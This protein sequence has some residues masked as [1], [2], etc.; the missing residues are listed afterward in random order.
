[1]ITARTGCR[2]PDSGGIAHGGG[3]VEPADRV[4]GLA[5]AVPHYGPGGAP[6]RPQPEGRGH[7]RRMSTAADRLLADVAETDPD[8]RIR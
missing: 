5:P 3:F 1:M 6:L 4:L 8:D 2:H 7:D